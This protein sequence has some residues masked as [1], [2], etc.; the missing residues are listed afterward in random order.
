M[1]PA[2][3]IVTELDPVADEIIVQLHVTLDQDGGKRSRRGTFTEVKPL[4]LSKHRRAVIK[5][6]LHYHRA[7]TR[8]T[9][10][11]TVD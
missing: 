1:H 3:P 2:Q 8:I 7:I 9:G 10:T 5:L 6:L 4:D 11:P